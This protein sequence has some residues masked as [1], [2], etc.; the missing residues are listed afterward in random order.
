MPKKI[1]VLTPRLPYP[2]I[3]GDKLRVYSI[4]ESLVKAGFDLTLLSFV[5]DSKEAKLANNHEACK[6]FSLVETVTLSKQQSY[7]NSFLGLLKGE[8][9]QTSYYKSRHMHKKVDE[10][11]DSSYQGV[12]V[13]LTR[14]AP[15][16]EEKKDIKKILEMTDAVS[17]NYN[18]SRMLG[19][20][21][22]LSAVYRAEASRAKKYEA[23][24]IEK[25]D[26]TVVVG[27]ADA[28]WLAQNI[29]KES[30]PKIKVIG[31]GIPDRLLSEDSSNYDPLQIVFLANMRTYQ[32]SD[33]VLYFIREIYPL[34]KKEKPEAKFMVL[35][36]SPSKEILAYNGK[37]GIQVTGEVKDI[38]PY[39]KNA[40]LSIC[41]VRI[42][43]GMQT[44]VLESMAVGVPVVATPIGMRG[45][46][47][48]QNEVHMYISE[49]EKRFAD[50]CLNLINMHR[51]RMEMSEAGRNLIREEYTNEVRLRD[52]PALFS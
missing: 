27:D 41:P 8:S 10:L 51:V 49:E 15:Y 37:N 18:R 7:L 32:N 17:L 31:L 50:Y 21:G 25:F 36:S 28:S 42:G 29:K 35:G 4:C 52:Y 33:A 6:I 3:G 46:I 11:L 2:I 13:H 34:I 1:L 39:L 14:M 43:A 5:T 38:L 26:A 23:Q 24:C 48:V 45:F 44:K 9:L 20:Q 19:T 30:I 47:E 22:F 40:C 12:L 16:V